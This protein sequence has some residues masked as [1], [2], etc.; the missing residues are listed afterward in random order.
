MTGWTDWERRALATIMETMLPA[1]S[2]DVPSLGELDLSEFWQRFEATAPPM[3]RLGLRGATWGLGLGSVFLL[4]RAASFD[5][6]TL[7]ERELLL[8]R[9]AESPV[10]V[11]RQM[12]VVVK[13]VA[14][15]AYFHDSEVQAW[16]RGGTAG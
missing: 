6:L 7:A 14:S 3:L 15:M 2:S 16:V 11:L 1:P 13:V 5:A 4:G 9:A 12:V 8:E 10:F